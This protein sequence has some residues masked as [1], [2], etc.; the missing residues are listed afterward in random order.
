MDITGCDLSDEE[1]LHVISTADEHKKIQTLKASKNRL[2]N[3][4]MINLFSFLGNCANLNLSYNQLTED[5][6]DEIIRLR[7][8]MKH[9]KILNLTQNKIINERKAKIKIEELKKVGIIVTI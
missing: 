5:I 3:F 7:G 9:L 4:G 2:T 8:S 6:L 1:I